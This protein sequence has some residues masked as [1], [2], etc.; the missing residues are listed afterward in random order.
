MKIISKE[1][2]I[3]YLNA[4]K[5]LLYEKYGVN[6]IGIFGSFIHGLQTHSSD[7]DLVIEM[8]RSRKNIHSYFRLKRFLEKELDR[9]VDLGFEHAIKPAVREKIKEEII[10]V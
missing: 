1:D 5:T 4:N 6:R 8:E 3:S 9:K 10:Y 7:V 2:I